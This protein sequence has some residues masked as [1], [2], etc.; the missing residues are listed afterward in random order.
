[1]TATVVVCGSVVVLL[2]SECAPLHSKQGTTHVTD[3]VVVVV[4]T[5]GCVVALTVAAVAV[6]VFSTVVV[7]SVSLHT[8]F[9]ATRNQR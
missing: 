4:V 5:V 3:V 1:M 6:L 9:V 8:V 2:T 7:T